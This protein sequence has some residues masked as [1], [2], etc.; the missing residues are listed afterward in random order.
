MSSFAATNNNKSKI[1][2]TRVGEEGSAKRNITRKKTG[3]SGGGGGGSKI[4]KGNIVDD[5]SLYTDPSALDEDDP[6]YDSEEETGK[7]FIPGTSENFDYNPELRSAIKNAKMTL[8]E[9]KKL[10]EV[11]IE[12]VPPLIS[13]FISHPYLGI[14]CQQ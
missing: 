8:S 3:K 1:P 14:L 9:Y 12:V 7:E 4:K 13:N 5:G 10:V 11:A 2:E 6:N